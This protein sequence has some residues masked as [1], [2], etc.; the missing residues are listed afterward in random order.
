MNV[1]ERWQLSVFLQ[2]NWR[3]WF[4]RTWAKSFCCIETKEL[5]RWELHNNLFHSI[6]NWEFEWDEFI[7][8]KI[9]ISHE[10]WW[11]KDMQLSF[12]NDAASS[13]FLFRFIIKHNWNDC[14]I[15]NIK[16]RFYFDFN[17]DLAPSFKTVLFILQSRPSLHLK[18][19]S[20]R[21]SL[22]RNLCKIA[23]KTNVHSRI[24]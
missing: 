14:A 10:L 1:C 6:C 22:L 19:I 9:A 7:S 23:D 2:K 5:N 13:D 21:R 17:C 15:K 16:E 11:N 8:K 18:K 20:H 4:W 3:W 24:A 12:C